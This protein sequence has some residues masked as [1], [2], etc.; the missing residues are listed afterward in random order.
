MQ[1]TVQTTMDH[2]MWLYTG[3]ESITSQLKTTC[4]TFYSLYT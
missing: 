4:L 2:T 1:Q 3:I